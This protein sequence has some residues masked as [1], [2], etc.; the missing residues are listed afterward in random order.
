MK[1]WML[2]CV[3]ALVCAT[4]ALAAPITLTHIATYEGN[5]CAG[6]FGDSF[7]ACKTPAAY[8]NSPIIAK[9]DGVWELNTEVFP[10]LSTD[11]FSVSLNDDRSGRFT[12]NGAGPNISY[13]VVKSGSY[14]N[15]FS[16]G[17]PGA[18]E[19]DFDNLPIPLKGGKSL[20]IS[21][22]SLF[23]TYSVPEPGSTLMM[24]GV[25]LI[26]LWSARKHRPS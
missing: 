4:S 15:L 6:V 11:M 9:W 10:L 21:H 2:A 19:F 5:D 18:I 23:D 1:R 13:V 7:A 24:L 16:T 22:V 17:A 8:G 14:F 25:G 12:Y 3:L 20:G 26:G